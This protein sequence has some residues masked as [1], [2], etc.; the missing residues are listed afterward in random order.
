MWCLCDGDWVC[1]MVVLCLC[2]G[3]FMK[4]MCLCFFWVLIDCI[5]ILFMVVCVLFVVVYIE[6]VECGIILIGILLL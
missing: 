2:F 5:V 4:V 6:I 3:D 1:C